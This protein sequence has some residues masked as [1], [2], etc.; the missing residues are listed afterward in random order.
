MRA[1]CKDSPYGYVEMSR[2]DS[3]YIVLQAKPGKSRST[4]MVQGHED[5]DL[6]IKKIAFDIDP[7]EAAVMDP[8]L[9][10]FPQSVSHMRFQTLVTLDAPKSAADTA[11][12]LWYKLWLVLKKVSTEKW[13]TFGFWKRDKP[14]PVQ[15]V[16]PLGSH[17]ASVTNRI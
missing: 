1:Q 2:S 14:Q 9:S 17:Q 12:V 6:E 8:L 4:L 13:I 11:R 7:D 15:L 10:H 5:L 3:L 16:T